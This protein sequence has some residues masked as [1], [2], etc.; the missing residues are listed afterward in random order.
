[1]HD[2]YVL[3][4]VWLPKNKHSEPQTINLLYLLEQRHSWVPNKHFQSTID[5]ENY[6]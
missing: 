6:K 5:R 1:M 4:H 3:P 2:P